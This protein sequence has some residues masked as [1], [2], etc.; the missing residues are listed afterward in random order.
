MR[1]A[2]AA[3]SAYKG[4]G[5]TAA[6]RASRDPKGSR[7][8]ACAKALMGLKMD[9]ERCAEL[10]AKVSEKCRGKSLMEVCDI[11]KACEETVLGDLR[12]FE[13]GV[14]SM[15][16]SMRAEIT[17]LMTAL[18]SHTMQYDVPVARGRL[19]LRSLT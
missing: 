14:A 16:D 4:L 2:R 6:V 7:L 1:S 19:G 5:I 18:D 9:L 12:V 13:Q 8:E 15:F 17:K 3:E 11:A 10:A